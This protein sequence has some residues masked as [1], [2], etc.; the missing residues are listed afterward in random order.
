MMA[1]QFSDA[2]EAFILKRRSFF[3]RELT[4]FPSPTSVGRLGSARSLFQLEEEV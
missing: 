4:G 3:G 2:Q 1:S